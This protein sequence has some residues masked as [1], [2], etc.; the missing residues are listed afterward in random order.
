M[1]KERLSEFC[2]QY[3]K[4]VTLPFFIMT[5][6]DSLLDEEKVK[7]LK[8]AGCVTIGIGVESGNEQIR[9]TLLNKNTSNAVYEKGFD[10]CHK[11]DLRTTANI[12]IGLPFETEENVLE[13]ARFCRQLRAR[14]I[15]LAIFAPYHGT[16]LRKI[17]IENGFI[18]DRLYDDIAIINASILTMPQLSKEKI[19]S[20]YY[21]FKDLVYG[22]GENNG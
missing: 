14:S 19:K 17:C 4:R 3:E 9:R 20:L 12:M 16:H 15:S 21:K 13:R 1:R 22:E 7:L 8:Q 10:N 11:H 6:A 2:E 18:E 5:R